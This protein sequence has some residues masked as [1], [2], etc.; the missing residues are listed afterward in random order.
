MKIYCIENKLNGKKYIGLTK[1]EIERRYKSHRNIA[2]GDKSK[3]QHI[4]KA[5]SLYGVKNFECY[6]ID[7]AENYQELCEKEKY[8]IKKL[9]T[10]NNGYNETDGGEGTIGVHPTEEQKRHLSE[11]NKQKWN[12]LTQEE[13]DKRKKYFNQVKKL[14]SGSKGKTWRLSDEAKKNIS[15]SKKGVPKSKEERIRL[16]I[17][18]TGAGN[19]NY[20]RKH[21]PETKEKMRQAALKRKLG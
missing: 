2:N 16:S 14:S 17:T 1:G 13:K 15:E 3:K 19:P 10:Q 5:M 4:H 21:S 7:T 6:E 8:W 20:G 9:D 11:L 12:N 18:R